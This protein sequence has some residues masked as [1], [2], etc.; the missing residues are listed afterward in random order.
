[1][2]CNCDHL[3]ATQLEVETSKVACLLGELKGIKINKDSWE[4]YHPDVYG[5]VDRKLADKLTKKLC[6]ALQKE[7][8]SKYSLE[9][10]IWWRDHQEADKKRI[11]KELQEEEDHKALKKALSKLTEHEKKLLKLS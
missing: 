4:G 8:V 10:Q 9:M 7:D 1:M 3:E 2:P 5:K 11:E 6:S